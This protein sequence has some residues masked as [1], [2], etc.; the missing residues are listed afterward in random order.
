MFKT[1]VEQNEGNEGSYF[2]FYPLGELIHRSFQG[3]FIYALSKEISW[4]LS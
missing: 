1:N 3:G 4:E 2:Y